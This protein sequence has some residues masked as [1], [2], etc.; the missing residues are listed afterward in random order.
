MDLTFGL[1]FDRDTRAALVGAGGKTSALFHLARA[2]DSIVLLTTTT[3]LALEQ[4][5][6]ADHH[7][8][9][10]DPTQ[11]PGE[12]TAYQD[13]IFLITGEVLAE[14][15]R[16]ESVSDSVME[17]VVD[18]A[19]R[20]QVPLLIEADGAR[21]LPLKAPAAHEPAIPSFVD[22]VIICAGLAG[23]GKPL[24]E[25]VVHRPQIF[26][27]IAGISPGE[28]ITPIHLQRVLLS[29]RGGL[30]NIPHGARKI[31]LLNQADVLADLRDLHPVIMTLLPTYPTVGV[32]AMIR[33]QVYAVHEPVAGIV[34]AGGGSQR[35]GK[36]KQLLNWQ[37]ESLVVHTAKTALKAGLDPVKVVTGADHREVRRAVAHLPVDTVHNPAWEEGQSTS[38]Q[39]GLKAL[40]SRVGGALFLLAD[41]P[42]IPPELVKALR[43]AHAESHAPIVA[44]MVEGQRANPVLF[45]RKVFPD[46]QSLRGDVGGRVLFERYQPLYV[47]WKD[48]VITL[49]VDTPG[50]FRRL[51][52]IVDDD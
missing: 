32:T 48:P 45:D 43:A 50:D 29:P 30:K 52:E 7:L 1:R 20:W 34:L 11:L 26:G 42:H 6:L 16:V 27:D 36:T 46:F 4:T 28:I 2:F 35:Y 5:T 38:V 41:Q 39:A 22:T 51:K 14:E 18:L 15:S 3:H 49:D 13:G 44:T 47:P 25:T 37:G 9:I 8:I 23:L 12:R 17:A 21:R 10:Q 24:S 19:N 31:V 33:D 40:S